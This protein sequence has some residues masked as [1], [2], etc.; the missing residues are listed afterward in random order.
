MTSPVSNSGRNRKSFQRTTDPLKRS[1]ASCRQVTGPS[2]LSVCA[3]GQGRGHAHYYLPH[4][5]HKAAG[6]LTLSQ[7]LYHMTEI[8]SH[9]ILVPVSS[10]RNLA[11]R[12]RSR[13]WRPTELPRLCFQPPLLAVSAFPDTLIPK[14]ACQHPEVSVDFLIS[15]C[16]GK[17]KLQAR[18][19][20]V[21]EIIGGCNSPLILIEKV[22]FR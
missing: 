17:I 14:P 5:G 13:E 15:F 16:V 2:M 18:E 20:F 8:G 3:G 4:G 6:P 11:S 21:S 9:D 22:I 1:S 7:H 10:L 12:M 19:W